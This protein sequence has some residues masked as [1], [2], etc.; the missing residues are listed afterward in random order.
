MLKVGSKWVR[1]MCPSHTQQSLSFSSHPFQPHNSLLFHFPLSFSKTVEL[2][3]LLL[4]SGLESMVMVI[5]FPKLCSPKASDS[6]L[7]CPSPFSFPTG[8]CPGQWT[9]CLPYCYVPGHRPGRGLTPPSPFL[10]LPLLLHHL[11]G[12]RLWT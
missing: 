6:A 9:L 2:F 3:M 5:L 4:L 11:P 12:T 10:G 7:T 1:H 8:H